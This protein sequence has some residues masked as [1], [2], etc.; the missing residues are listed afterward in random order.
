MDVW[1]KVFLTA[2]IIALGFVVK[3][4][5]KH[6]VH[7][8]IPTPRKIQRHSLVQ[9]SSTI[10]WLLVIIAIISLWSVDVQNLWVFFT[11]VLGIVAIGF[12]AVWSILS[13]VVAGVI[14]LL[15]QSVKIGDDITILPEDIKGKVVK[16]TL[17]FVT[18]KDKKHEIH[19]PNNQF[20]QKFIKK[21]VS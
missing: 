18:L 16:I 3:A 14:L 15:S 13:N 4:I 17:M 8:R 12:F 19:I 9:V 2:G 5:L 6:V 10:V 21:K 1:T 7:K 20:F 11:S